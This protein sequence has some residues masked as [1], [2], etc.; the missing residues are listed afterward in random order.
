MDRF[1]S[2]S[3]EKI[4]LCTILIFMLK[5]GLHRVNKQINLLDC[6]LQ[7]LLRRYEL[8]ERNDYASIRTNIMIRVAITEGVRNMLNEWATARCEEIVRLQ[9][10]VVVYERALMEHLEHGDDGVSDGF[11]SDDDDDDAA[12]VDDDENVFEVL[13]VSE[14]EHDL[15]DIESNGTG[16]LVDNSRTV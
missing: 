13:N 1:T 16:Q 6:H 8:S 11:A 3:L 4:E 5:R 14:S 9:R 12:D 10:S 15:T 7:N 2:T